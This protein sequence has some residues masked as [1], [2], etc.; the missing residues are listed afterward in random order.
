[1]LRTLDPA[2]FNAIAAHPEVHPWLGFEDPTA[3]PDLTTTV[4]NLANVCFLTSQKEGGYILV[5]QDPGL[6]T[7]HTLALPAA[8]GRPMARLMRDG[9]FHMF[10]A[11][12]A[13]E[14][15]TSV[16]DGNENAGAWA[17]LAG[18]RP[19]FRREGVHPLMGE[20]VGVQWMSLR[21]ED[22]VMRDPHLPELGQ[23]FHTKLE[24]FRGHASHGEDPLH[25]RWVGFTLSAA[26]EGNLDKGIGL[27]NRW[28]TL[29]GYQRAVILDRHPV[30]VD[31]GD[32]I[33]QLSHS[34]LDV[35]EARSAAATH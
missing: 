3:E 23:L 28:A 10:T 18:F 6:Y 17:E 20:R 31:I 34:A 29:A 2:P 9:F 22:W 30:L 7:A 25:D 24:A 14:I 5:K 15:T 35:L 19:T 13:I 27:Y 32:A 4:R 12:D 21:L 8:R 33:V 1:M 26:M 11:T 16:A